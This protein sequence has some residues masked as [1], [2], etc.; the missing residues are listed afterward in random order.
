MDVLRR[1]DAAFYI[2][3]FSD[4]RFLQMPIADSF[5]FLPSFHFI[6][7]PIDDDLQKSKI[8]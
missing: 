6:K 2:T 3:D 5:F 8:T 7:T 1:K 4:R